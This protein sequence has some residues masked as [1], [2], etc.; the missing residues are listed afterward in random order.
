MN[1][2]FLLALLAGSLAGSGLPAFAANAASPASE[3]AVTAKHKP[4]QY[5]KET[6][7]A[8]GKEE[9]KETRAQEEKEK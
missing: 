3:P 2:K 1:P 9:R 7:K 4:V 5:T 6:K 8:E